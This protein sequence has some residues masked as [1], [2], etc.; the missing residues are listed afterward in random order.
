MQEEF[1]IPS[2]PALLANEVQTMIRSVEYQFLT[3]TGKIEATI[4]I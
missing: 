2:A 3:C 1:I 4:D